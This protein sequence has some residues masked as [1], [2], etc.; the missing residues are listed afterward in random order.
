MENL[1]PRPRDSSEFTDYFF[2]W[3]IATTSFPTCDFEAP[4]KGFRSFESSLCNNWSNHQVLDVNLGL[5]NSMYVFEGKH[6]SNFTERFSTQLKK[7]FKNIA[8]VFSFILGVKHLI[9]HIIWAWDGLRILQ[10][11]V[12]PRFSIDRV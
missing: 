4:L 8:R 3:S 7:D 1:L 11:I 9:L 10:K 6:L 2:P 5:D 12:D